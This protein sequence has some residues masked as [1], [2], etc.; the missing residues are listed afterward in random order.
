MTQHLHW[1]SRIAV[2][3]VT[4]LAT[5]GCASVLRPDPSSGVAVLCSGYG[6]TP[7]KA[8]EDAIVG[9]V[10]QV[11][12][13]YVHAR[14][15]L[16]DDA[17][18]EEIH[19][20]A[21][22]VLKSM[23]VLDTQHTPAEGW[24]V[25]IRGVVEPHEVYGA[26]LGSQLVVEQKV[27][28]E[29]LAL[30]VHA[31]QLARAR[32][33]TQAQ[34][35]L[36]DL[37]DGF[38]ESYLYLESL[39]PLRVMDSGQGS[40]PSLLECQID[41]QLK[42]DT[43]RYE[44]S[45]LPALLQVLTDLSYDSEGRELRGTISITERWPPRVRRELDRPD[46]VREGRPDDPYFYSVWKSH[47]PNKHPILIYRRREGGGFLGIGSEADAVRCSWFFVDSWVA[48]VIRKHRLGTSVPFNVQL[49]ADAQGNPGGPGRALLARV[50]LISAGDRIVSMASGTLVSAD[51]GGFYLCGGGASSVIASVPFGLGSAGPKH[52]S[53]RWQETM[54]F[55]ATF[56]LT[57][58]QL[59]QV[60]EVV[61][62][63]Y[64][65]PL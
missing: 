59:E 23:T 37:L 27:P 43:L 61:T 52:F 49:L 32:Y 19:R 54:A 10:E 45:L 14:A 1:C 60:A 47:Y 39:G 31:Q 17:Y 36:E 34:G 44:K 25:S 53:L 3:L 12:K 65:E 22:G 40:D 38:P 62:S 55:T 4:S 48:P 20:F 28:G 29:E 33:R 46:R 63:V 57:L 7:E 50:Q 15:S 51:S 8:R 11:A 6:A 58:E 26:L 9:A 16:T 21:A 30:Q 41:Y 5:E 18:R 64:T 42:F 35:V 24:K 56:S 13:Q 2:V